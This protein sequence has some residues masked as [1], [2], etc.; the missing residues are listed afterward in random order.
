MCAGDE[1]LP[2]CR[3][4]QYG[5]WTAHSDF[6]K[7]EA[8]TP[9]VLSGQDYCNVCKVLKQNRCGLDPTE[10]KRKKKHQ[11]ETKFVKKKK[12]KK[13]EKEWR[14]GKKGRREERMKKIQQRNCLS[15]RADSLP[16]CHSKPVEKEDKTES[17]M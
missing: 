3:A 15:V 2:G 5:R 8:A 10:K 12:E 11:T 6:Q 4:V 9:Q 1:Y 14:K 13:K 16:Q 7:Q 17:T